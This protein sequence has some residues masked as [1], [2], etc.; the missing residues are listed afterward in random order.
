MLTDMTRQLNS[1]A[2]VPADIIKMLESIHK[3]F[4]WDKKRPN[5]KHLTL[6]SDYSKGP[7]NRGIK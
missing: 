5:V 1:M 4:I 6:I 2:S 7:N 3:D